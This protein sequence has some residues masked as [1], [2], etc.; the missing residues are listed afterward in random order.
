MNKKVYAG[1]SLLNLLALIV[2]C[3]QQIVPQSQPKQ[4]VRKETRKSQNND[5]QPDKLAKLFEA[6]QN[7]HQQGELEKAVELYTEALKIDPSVWQVELQLGLVN[8]SLKRYS[9]AHIAIGN[10][11]S[12]LQDS[13]ELPEVKPNYIRA[14]IIQGEICLAQGKYKESENYFQQALKLNSKAYQAFAGLAELMFVQENFTSATAYARSAIANGDTST[15]ILLLLAESLIKQQLKAE[16]VQALNLIL[17]REPHLLSAL[18]QRA[19]ILLEQG[20][21]SQAIKDLQLTNKLT[22]DIS[23][24]LALAN[25]YILAKLPQEAIVM[26]QQISKD[27]PS[28]LEATKALAALYVE[29]GKDKEAIAQLESVVQTEPANAWVHEQL[30]ELYL[31]VNPERAFAH[32]SSA[33]KLVPDNDAYKVGTAT[34]LVKLR[35]FQEAIPILRMVISQ[36]QKGNIVY[37]AH[38]NLATALFELNDFATAA[39][40]FV[41]I[42]ENVKEQKR[43]AVSLYFLGICF[44]KLGD[45]QQALKAYEQFLGMANQENQLEID[46]VKLRLPPLQRQIKEGKGKKS[47]K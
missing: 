14:H 4:P 31:S 26:Y 24:K 11:I 34:A 41:W 22:S 9:Q 2:L 47:A 27:D 8:V 39:R 23:D 38:T 45:Y 15:S 12:I 29:T 20:E 40:E 28:N 16:A 44:D 1:K 36:S 35:R 37:F 21:Y 32:Y 33:A 43:A 10:V 46:K 3:S 17:S 25:A 19:E 18:R 7:A 30:A 6:G 13:A 5:T 42:L